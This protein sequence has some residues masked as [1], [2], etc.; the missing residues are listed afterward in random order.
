VT[1]GP[2]SEHDADLHQPEKGAGESAVENY[3]KASIF[4][5]PKLLD[6][7]QRIDRNPMAKHGVLDVGSKLKVGNLVPNMLY[8]CNR[9]EHL[10]AG[11]KLNFA[12]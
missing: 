5:N 7:L 12:L 2:S 6:S 11:S 4:P 10:R 1:P 3:F 9:L 8:E